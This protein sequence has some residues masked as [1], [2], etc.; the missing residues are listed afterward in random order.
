ME[1]ERQSLYIETTIPSYATARMS[2]DLVIAGRQVLTQF[3]WEHLRDKYK[4][5]VSQ[6]VLNEWSLSIVL[7][8]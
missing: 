3:F 4:L 2:R 7:C 5:Y 8:K 6:A 1:E